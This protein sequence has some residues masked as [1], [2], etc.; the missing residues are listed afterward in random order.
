MTDSPIKKVN[1]IA[2]LVEDID[3]AAAFWGE[4]LGLTMGH[5]EDVPQENAR[6]AFFPVGE[7]KIELVQPTDPATGL[8]KY[9]AK[10][11][12]GIHHICLEVED[13]EGVL[14]DL[15]AKDV[16]LI[17]PTPQSREDGTLYAFIH[18]KSAFGVLVELYQVPETPY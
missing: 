12:A 10:R 8:G 17:N 3:Q 11:G 14:A 18:P 2:M 9:L 6:V 7:S 15:K 1:H 5:I 13:I 16:Q 4:A